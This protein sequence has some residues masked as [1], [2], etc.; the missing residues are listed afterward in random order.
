MSEALDRFVR[1]CA[2]VDAERCAARD[3]TPAYLGRVNGHAYATDGHLLALFPLATLEAGAGHFP[4]A[5]GID[6]MPRYLEA[7]AAPPVAVYSVDAAALAEW[8]GEPCWPTPADCEMCDG[9]ALCVCECGH[10]HECG[11]CEGGKWQAPPAD[12]PALVGPRQLL[13][14]VLLGRLLDVLGRD[15][16]VAIQ[17]LGDTLTRVQAGDRIGYVAHLDYGKY[18]A[19]ELERFDRIPQEWAS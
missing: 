3:V 1:H 16:A 8:C 18:T 14:R 4:D 2:E 7:P 19:E 10:E 11:D 9:T 17:V 15:G 6:A 5:C 12:R 13:N